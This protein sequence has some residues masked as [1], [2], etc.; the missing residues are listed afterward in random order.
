M[1]NPLRTLAQVGLLSLLA[2]AGPCGGPAPTGPA[3]QQSAPAPPQPVSPPAAERPSPASAAGIPPV[4][5]DPY[6][7]ALQLVDSIT[8]LPVLDKPAL[9]RLLGVPMLR[10]PA[11]PPEALYY[12]VA[13][14]E[15]PFARVEVRTSNPKQE[16]FE[17][18]LLESRASSALLLSRFRSLERIKDNMP[19]ATNPR[20]PP[21][22]TLTF[23]D[24]SGH[25][26]V[27]HQTVRYTFALDTQHLRGVT[28]ERGPPK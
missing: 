3:P 18:V 15:G 12:E 24:R 25:Q 26:T 22:G 16:K 7:R 11:A 17:M 19:T 6:I 13:L 10:S 5:S 20:L 28:V 2:A 8:S 27:G 21:A 4:P 14:P 9:E 23:L 1:R